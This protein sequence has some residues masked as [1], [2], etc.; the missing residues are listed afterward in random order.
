MNYTP[1]LSQTEQEILA[2]T[3]TEVQRTCTLSSGNF[4][5][6]IVKLSDDQVRTVA[7]SCQCFG[8]PTFGKTYV[9][10]DI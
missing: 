2:K 3:F 8:I 4:V 6:L 7:I 10:T 1:Y 9:P 5:A